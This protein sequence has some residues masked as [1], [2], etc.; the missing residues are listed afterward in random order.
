MSFEGEAFGFPGLNLLPRMINKC[1]YHSDAMSD[2][3]TGRTLQASVQ[4]SKL[5]DEA[6]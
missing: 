1:L 5:N 6:R 4:E 3:I 2:L